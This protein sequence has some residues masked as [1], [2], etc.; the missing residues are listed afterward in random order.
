MAINKLTPQYLN[1]DTDQKL[2]KSVE[3]TDNLNVRVSNDDEGTAG[4]VKNI[5]GTTVVGAKTNADAFPTGTNRVI[6]SVANETNK[7]IIFLLYNEHP[8]RNHGIYKLDMISGKYQ[9]VYEDSVL[10]FRKYTYT[11]CDVIVNEENE[12][13]FYWTDDVNPPMKVNINRLMRKEYPFQAT[14]YSGTDED[15]LLSLTVAKQPPLT[16]PTFTFVRDSDLFQNNINESLFQFAYQYKY[17]D[18]EYLSLIH[19]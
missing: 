15:K 5:K 6:A 10:N 13:L 16:P 9:K 3:M 12:T 18:G 11:D 8:N 7:E 1:S 4:V 17:V 14:G 2:V 19:I